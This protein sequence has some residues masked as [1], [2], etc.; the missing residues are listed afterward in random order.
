VSVRSLVIVVALITST[1]R[2]AIAIDSPSRRRAFE[3]EGQLGWTDGAQ[4]G[5][6]T[7][8]TVGRLRYGVV[9]AGAG[10]QV[11][12]VAFTSMASVS[13]LAGLSLPVGSLRIDALS[14]LGLN[15]YTGVGS[16]F[17]TDDPG[18][19]AVLPFLGGRA[20]L[21]VRAFNTKRG[22]IWVGLSTVYAQD[23]YARTS[24]YA[25]RSHGSDWF[26]GEYY[27]EQRSSSIEIGQSRF[28]M[29]LTTCASLPF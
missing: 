27:D 29:L 21:L 22:D 25:Y 10:L 4:S 7:G 18:A 13:T 2:K 23:L 14:E 12:T 11:A 17:L 26:T 9:T 20:S 5:G 15:A 1:S 3:F 19:S 6:L 8:G 24:E 28:A 16:N